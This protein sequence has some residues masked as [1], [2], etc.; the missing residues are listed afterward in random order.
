MVQNKRWGK[1]FV[2]KRDHKKYQNELLKRYTIYLD[3]EWVVS[4][5]D[6]LAKMNKGK[7]GAPY[8]FPNSMIAWQSLLVEKFSTRG[9]EAIT[10][11][12]EGFKL[13]PKCNNF[14][15]IYRRIL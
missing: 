12:L 2:D 11:K 6:E 10:R 13:I 9:A 3:L 4:W 8:Q 15:T 14:A 1:K 5:N 7:K